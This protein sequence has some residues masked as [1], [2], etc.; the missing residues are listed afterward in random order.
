M[1]FDK[2]KN[3]GYVTPWCQALT[4]GNIR[5]WYYEVST[6]SNEDTCSSL[7]NPKYEETVKTKTL[8]YH[9]EAPLIK[10]KTFHQHLPCQSYQTSTLA[11]Y[12]L[13]PPFELNSTIHI[14][15]RNITS[16]GTIKEIVSLE[17]KKQGLKI[18]VPKQSV[19]DLVNTKLGEMKNTEGYDYGLWKLV[20]YSAGINQDEVIMSKKV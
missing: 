18:S 14:T 3:I 6:W 15:S 11:D 20:R 5:T 12:P 13:T 7:N 19:Y 10:H 1:D 4:I 2:I 9:N 16:T 8:Q 17:N